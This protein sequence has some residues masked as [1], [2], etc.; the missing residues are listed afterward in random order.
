LQ[1]DL[2]PDGQAMLGQ[3]S[4]AV[5]A[6]DLGRAAEIA[7]AAIKA[8]NT[9]PA[10]FNARALFAQQ[11]GRHQ[12]ALDEFQKALALTP[13][14]PLLLKATGMCLV[15]LN[16]P[17]EGVKLF[18]AALR[19]EPD[20]AQTWYFKGWALSA[21]RDQ[22]RARRAYERAVTLRADYPEALAALATIAAH[23]GDHE[24]ARH[25]ARRALAVNPREHGAVIVLAMCDLAEHE[26]QAGERQLKAM[27]DD[28]AVVGQP[29]V[30]ALGYYADALDG[31]GRF[32]AAFAAYTARNDE[33][34][35]LHASRLAGQGSRPFT[36]SLAGYLRMSPAELWATPAPQELASRAREHVFLMG[37]LR[38]GTTLLEQILA[39]HPDVVHLEERETLIDLSR[40]YLAGSEGLDR[41]AALS[42]DEL[43]GLRA[44]YWRQV[45]SFGVNPRR[46]VFIDKQP[47]N[48]F[49]LPLIA[50]LFPRAKILFAIRDPRDVV[51]SCFRR[52]FDVN[53]VMFEFLTLEDG[54]RFYS[55]VMDLADAA[56]TKL[57]LDVLEH[58]YE[59]MIADFEGRV[60]RVCDWLG[61]AWS[62]EMR[63]FSVAAQ[64]RT[65][66]SPSAGQ[67]RRDLYRSAV[68]SWRNYE[69]QLAPVLPILE[70][71]V[72]RFGYAP[73]G[74]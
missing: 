49:N 67:V 16:R 2:T 19:L 1:I 13:H 30:L 65:I 58:R 14:N 22:Q 69:A 73:D 63:D 4:V 10:F 61:I 66:R 11:Q 31:Q 23:A 44:Q 62:D 29:R 45:E 38:S 70:P 60:R 74:S 57:P 3:L 43:E 55:A 33:I 42:A 15:R 20:D 72:K 40:T 21:D 26:Y 59:D 47:L 53:A 9:H 36:E 24:T 37:F 18:D 34:R 39:V 50:R 46:K 51:L 28:R 35:A 68:E 27:L 7:D 48:V 54:A 12:A 8:G 71:W 56:R 5:G 41:L 25:L 52:H 17:E 6:N 32:T 64:N